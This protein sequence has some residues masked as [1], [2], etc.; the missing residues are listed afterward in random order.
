MTWSHPLSYPIAVPHG[1]GGYSD[2]SGV[3]IHC[4]VA[5]VVC[6]SWKTDYLPN[7][8]AMKLI[9]ARHSKVDTMQVR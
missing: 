7:D 6:L 4:Q 3:Q 2:A 5:Y 8:L 9:M 1:S